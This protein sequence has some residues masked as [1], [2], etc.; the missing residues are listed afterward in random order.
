MTFLSANSVRRRIEHG[1]V[2]VLALIEI[3]SLTIFA[4]PASARPLYQP[5]PSTSLNVPAQTPIGEN[6]SFT[7]TF[8]NL[9]DTGYGPFIDLIFP[10][11]GVDGVFPFGPGDEADGIDFINVTY[12]GV[13]VTSTVLV[14][15]SAS[16]SVDHP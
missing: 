8:D 6:F 16:G 3:F 9:G 12:L 10:Y 14:F 7:V 15:P 11:T 2:I 1:F 5:S 13:P 4:Q